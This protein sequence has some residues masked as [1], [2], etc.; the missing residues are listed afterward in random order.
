MPVLEAIGRAG[1]KPWPRLLHA[2]RASRQTD[3]NDRYAGHVVAAWLG[4]SEKVADA[5]YNRITPEHW[6]RA[7]E[8]PGADVAPNVGQPSAGA[9]AVR[10]PVRA[11]RARGGTGNEKPP[12]LGTGG[13]PKALG[14]CLVPPLGLEPRTPL[15]KSQRAGNGTFDGDGTYGIGGSGVTQGVTN[16]ASGAYIDPD[17]QAVIDRWPDLPDGIRDAIAKLAQS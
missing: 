14:S 6:A 16:S 2:L 17:L 9:E 15:I 1:L 7:V 12:V 3:L 10:I 4:N 5:H 13:H 8:D 11:G